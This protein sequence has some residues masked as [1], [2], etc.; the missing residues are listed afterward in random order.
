[1]GVNRWTAGLP[2]LAVSAVQLLVVAVLAAGSAFLLERPIPAPSL[3]LWGE[4][5]Y[6]AVFA[7]LATFTLML[8]TAE[9]LPLIQEL[10]EFVTRSQFMYRHQW[11][12][13]DVLMWDNCCVQH[14]AIKDYELPQ[15]RLMHRVTLKG[16]IPV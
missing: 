2:V 10:S 8:P 7:T 14:L 11:R 6:L 15:R 12:V 1:V 4:I 9:S 16:S 13:G 5:V 3:R